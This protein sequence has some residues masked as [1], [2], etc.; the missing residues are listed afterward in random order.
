MLNIRE[1][2]LIK[3]RF[4]IDLECN[5]NNNLRGTNH[6]FNGQNRQFWAKNGGNRPFAFKKW[7]FSYRILILAPISDGFWHKN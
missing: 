4:K 5:K 2:R 1:G 6:Y 3:S 7:P